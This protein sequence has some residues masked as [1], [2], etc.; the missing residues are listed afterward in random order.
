MF[1]AHK[2]M[3]CGTNEGGAEDVA[4]GRY[5]LEGADANEYLGLEEEFR[6]NK[7]S[8]LFLMKT[9]QKDRHHIKK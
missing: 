1:M 4:L 3:P 2:I 7:V 6:P 5:K 9:E 8:F